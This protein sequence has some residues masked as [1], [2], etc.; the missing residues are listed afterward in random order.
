MVLVVNDRAVYMAMSIPRIYAVDL[1][2]GVGGLSY[3]LKAAGIKVVAG[4]DLDVTC[5]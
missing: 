4:Y 1:F 3:G 5:K 2:C